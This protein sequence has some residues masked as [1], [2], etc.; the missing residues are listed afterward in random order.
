MKHM[1]SMIIVMS[2]SVLLLAGCATVSL[3][4]AEEKQQPFPGGYGA[5]KTEA[6]PQTPAVQLPPWPPEI[7][8]EPLQETASAD[9]PEAPA[10][11]DVP[12]PPVLAS[13]P[14]PEAPAAAEVEPPAAAA[15]PA[16]SEPR[17]TE[18]DIRT[19]YGVEDDTGDFRAAWIGIPVLLLLLV[20]ILAEFVRWSVCRK[21]MFAWGRHPS[22]REQEGEETVLQETE[23]REPG[24]NRFL[25]RVDR[26]LDAIFADIDDGED[27]EDI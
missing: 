14:G 19:V 10:V 16:V 23:P 26:M 21:P 12:K 6:A 5:G 20:I 4:E 8:E 25:R 24:K 1:R 11:P 2:I 13:L 17:E 9:E 22:R 18:T 15:E 27:G 3:P 7:T